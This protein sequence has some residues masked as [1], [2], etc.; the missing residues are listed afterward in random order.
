LSLILIVRICSPTGTI[1]VLGL[2]GSEVGVISKSDVISH[3]S[4]EDSIPS[5]RGAI[6]RFILHSVCSGSH[7]Y[8]ERVRS[9]FQSK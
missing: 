4:C 1:E 8:S 9:S 7:V 5:R 2:H 6:L 3:V